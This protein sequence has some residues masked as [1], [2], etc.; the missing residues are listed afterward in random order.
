MVA[1]CAKRVGAAT[2]LTP[3]AFHVLFMLAFAW[4]S[5]FHCRVHYQSANGVIT[6]GYLSFGH[7]TQCVVHT[8]KGLACLARVAPASSH[9]SLCKQCSALTPPSL[10]ARGCT[11]PSRAR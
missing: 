6:A 1:A 3:Q 11:S 10:H 5:W 9:A 7:M 8:L 4:L 2:G